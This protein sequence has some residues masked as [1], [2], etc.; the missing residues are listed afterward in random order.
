MFLVNNQSAWA[1]LLVVDFLAE[2]GYVENLL[3][4]VLDFLLVRLD[5]L[6]GVCLLSYVYGSSQGHT[7]RLSLDVDAD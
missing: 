7:T 4:G 5:V 1:C 6:E 3:L 2:K